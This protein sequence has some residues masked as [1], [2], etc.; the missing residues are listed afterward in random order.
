MKSKQGTHWQK[1]VTSEKLQCVKIDTKLTF[2]DHIRDMFGEGNSNLCAL[3]RVTPYMGLGKKKLL[4]SSFL[5]AQFNYCALI[6]RF[7][8]RSNNKKITH[9]NEKCLRLIYSDKS[10]SYEEL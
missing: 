9:L 4:I 8:G 6:W 1:A 7:H 5:A 10:S 2:D 3:G